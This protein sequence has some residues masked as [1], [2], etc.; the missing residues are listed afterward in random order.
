MSLVFDLPGA[1]VALYK[2][3]RQ[4]RELQD[5]LRL[6]LSCGFSGFIALTGTWGALLLAH[7]P[8]W[9]SF[10]GGLGACAVAVFTVLLRMKQGRSLMVVAPT[11][12]V[13]QYEADNQTVVEPK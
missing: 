2:A 1:A 10:G 12:T 9:Y 4:D 3:I 13:K 5:W 6:V 7:D 8:A 11:A